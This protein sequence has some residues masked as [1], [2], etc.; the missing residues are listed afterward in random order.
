M[1]WS[2]DSIAARDYC[3][4]HVLARPVIKWNKGF[5]YIFSL[6]LIAFLLCCTSFLLTNHL[7]WWEIEIYFFISFL[8]LGKY[9]IVFSIEV[10]Q[11]YAPDHVRRRCS[12]MPSCSEYALI[13]LSKYFW[14]K[15]VILIWRRV[16]ITCLKPGYHID[17]P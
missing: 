7:H 5:A 6:F 16:F 1:C 15:A 12:C 4:N 3:E 13:A 17:F 14:I 8:L 2:A 9:I 10:Y 11:K